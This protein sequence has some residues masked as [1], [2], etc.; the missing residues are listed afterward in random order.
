MKPRYPYVKRRSSDWG[1]RWLM[2]GFAVAYLALVG[3][4]LAAVIRG[5][6]L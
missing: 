3:L 5:L 2:I 6:P 4:I 1:P